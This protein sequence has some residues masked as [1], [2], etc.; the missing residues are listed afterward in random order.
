MTTKRRDFRDEDLHRYTVELEHGFWSG[1]RAISVNGREVIRERRMFGFDMG[2]QHGFDV[3]GHA[4]LL[5]IRTS[6]V[7]YAYDL[8]VDGIAIAPQGTTIPRPGPALSAR[9]AISL[10]QQL[11]V[12]AP[13]PVKAQSALEQRVRNGGRWS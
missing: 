10:P 12:T 2:S 6:G 8:Y 9:P 1:K 11:P 5:R 7:T 4:A 3:D 13:T